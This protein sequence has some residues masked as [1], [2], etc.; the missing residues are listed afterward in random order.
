[1]WRPFSMVYFPYALRVFDYWSIKPFLNT[2]SQDW[3]TVMHEYCKFPPCQRYRK[4][5]PKDQDICRGFCIVKCVEQW[6]IWK[7][8]L[9]P[10]PDVKT[11]SGVAN[12][13]RR[14]IEFARI[15]FNLGILEVLAKANNSTDLRTASANAPSNSNLLEIKWKCY[16]I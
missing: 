6:R 9:L 13:R 8:I 1:M 3:L 16:K 11:W 14:T 12:R 5:L 2:Y 4:A 15:Q 7:I 10:T